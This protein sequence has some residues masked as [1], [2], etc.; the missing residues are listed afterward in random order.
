VRA[1]LDPDLTLVETMLAPPPLEEARRSLEYWQRRRQALPLY[2]RRARREASE[3]AARWQ[4]RVRA[5]ERVRFE[6]T[7]IGRILAALGLSS[8]FARRVRPTKVGVI[9]LAWAFVPLKIKLVAAGVVATWLI[10][11]IAALTAVA[12]FVRLA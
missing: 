10:V 4:E 2:R 3:M 7:L 11:L 5:A 8:V 12:V 6:S 9:A 1:Q